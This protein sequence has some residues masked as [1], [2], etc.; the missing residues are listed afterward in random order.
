MATIDEQIAEL[1]KLKAKEEY[2]KH[3]ELIAEIEKKGK[4]MRGKSYIEFD[5]ASMTGNAYW[6]VIHIT[7]SRV[8]D[9]KPL[10]LEVYADEIHINCAPA[11]LVKHTYF[12]KAWSDPEYSKSGGTNG[13]K[14]LTEGLTGGKYS[15]RATFRKDGRA[16][17]NSIRSIRYCRY[18]GSANDPVFLLDGN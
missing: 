6:K 10:K 9:S 3:K 18:N 17:K 5:G 8:R 2:N 1:N 14:T 7:D 4:T 13:H 16:K 11:L 15:V 12:D